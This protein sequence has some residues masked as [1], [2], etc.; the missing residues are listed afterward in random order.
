MIP[1]DQSFVEQ[2]SIHCMYE[3]YQRCI[4]RKVENIVFLG[5]GYSL[6]KGLYVGIR[7]TSNSSNQLARNVWLTLSLCL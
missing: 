2:V 7:R 3:E 6:F 5:D 1:Y 4:E